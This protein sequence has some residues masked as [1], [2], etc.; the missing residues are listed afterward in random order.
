MQLKTWI[1]A[2]RLRTLPLAASGILMGSYSAGIFGEADWSIMILALITAL[3]LQI[4]SNLANDYGDFMKGTD[5]ENRI[6]NMRAL[7]SGNI[8]PAQMKIAI[9][10]TIICCLVC[11]IWLLMLAMNGHLNLP[12]LLFLITGIFGIAAA[13]K[14]TV[15]KNPYGYGGLG[16]IMVF[17]FFGPVSVAGTFLLHHHIEI[18][19]TEWPVWC[20]SGII[21]LLSAAVLNTNNIRDIENDTAFGKKTIPVRFGIK[22]ARIY[23]FI[24]ILLAFVCNII[25]LL[26]APV[27]PFSWIS[28][29]AFVP[30]FIQAKKV[31]V[32][33]PS[34]AFNAMLKQV[35][36]GTF[37]LV[38]LFILSAAL[39]NMYTIAQ[40]I[41]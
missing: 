21:G 10:L 40:I 3:L 4:L 6:G 23:H 7:Q 22:K 30:L 9:I 17:I 18:R 41:K 2:L 25:F 36:L 1:S 27:H 14:Y 20:A 5:N 12:F 8:T 33:T 19:N 35:S 37:F 38:L 26:N 39:G 15:G 29:I 28:I 16:D 31:I 32:T 11:G 34:P 24:L 13:L